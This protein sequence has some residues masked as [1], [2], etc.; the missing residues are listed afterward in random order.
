MNITTL[1]HSQRYFTESLATAVMW[2]RIQIYRHKI[3]GKAEFNLTNFDLKRSKFR[4]FR[5][6]FENSFI[7]LDF[8]KYCCKSYTGFNWPGAWIFKFCGYGYIQ[9][10][11]TSLDDCI[12]WCQGHPVWGGRDGR[13]GRRSRLLGLQSGS[14]GRQRTSWPWP[15]VPSACQTRQPRN[16]IIKIIR[17][18]HRKKLPK[19]YN[20]FG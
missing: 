16:Y 14:S 7:F 20:V 10:G 11:S 19:A 6:I 18:R 3:K 17:R 15:S 4:R 5:Y 8:I 1:R 12:P 9:S 2:I 13:P